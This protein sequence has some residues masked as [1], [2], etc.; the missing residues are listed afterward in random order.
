MERI[1]FFLLSAF[2]SLSIIACNHDDDSFACQAVTPSDDCI[3]YQVYAPVC[4][5]DGVT[6]SNDCIARCHGIIDFEAGECGN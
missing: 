4:G 2:F 5:C 3:C 1:R 6:Y